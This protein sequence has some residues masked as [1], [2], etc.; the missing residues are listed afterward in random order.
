MKT[1]SSRSTEVAVMIARCEQFKTYGALRAEHSSSVT[2]G[3]LPA[4]HRERLYADRDDNGGSL[5][6]VYSYATPIAW[7]STAWGWRVPPVRYSVT[8]SKHQGKL[9]RLARP[10]A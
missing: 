9:Y 1:V 5:Y 4:E 3:Q 7:Y 8:T 2:A 6:V 10:A